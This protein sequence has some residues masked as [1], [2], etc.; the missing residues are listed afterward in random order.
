MIS[1]VTL[2]VKTNHKKLIKVSHKPQKRFFHFYKQQ[3]YY[4]IC[5]RKMKA[6]IIYR[7]SIVLLMVSAFNFASQVF[8]SELELDAFNLEQTDSEKEVD[9]LDLEKKETVLENRLQFEGGEE[10]IISHTFSDHYTILHHFEKI[11]TPPPEA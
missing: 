8:A 5:E 3:P 6:S 7:I 9:D 10:S 11:P 1:A 4:Y 2:Y